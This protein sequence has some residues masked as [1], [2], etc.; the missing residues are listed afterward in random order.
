MKKGDEKMTTVLFCAIVAVT[1]TM[2]TIA[3]DT[4]GARVVS[5]VLV[6]GSV[7]MRSAK[8]VGVSLDPYG[9]SLFRLTAVR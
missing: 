9:F 1:N 7:E 3:V 5:Y 6:G 4:H 8:S 2:G